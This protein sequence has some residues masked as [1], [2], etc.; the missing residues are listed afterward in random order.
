METEKLY[1]PLKLYI[2]DSPIAH[3]DAFEYMEE[4]ERAMLSGREDMDSTRGLAEHIPDSL[5]DVVISLFPNIER[6]GDRLWCVADVTL[7][8][9]ITPGEMGELTQWWEGQLTDVWGDDLEQRGIEVNRGNL[10]LQPW[11][12]NDSYYFIATQKEFNRQ[13]GYMAVCRN[14][15]LQPGDL[16]LST[17]DN[18]YACLVGTVIAVKK[19]GITEHG[20]GNPGNEI[21]V[22][23]TLAE[24]TPNQAD[25]ARYMAAHRCGRRHYGAG[26]ALPHHGHRPEG[27]GGYP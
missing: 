18:D 7:S 15:Q 2:G 19:A 17:A 16:V 6:H 26:D 5:D 21:H 27:L 12:V 20:A 14:G 24:Y 22:D 1:S 13:M 8:R 3:E 9:P 4:I 23:F 11:I 10:Y 25:N